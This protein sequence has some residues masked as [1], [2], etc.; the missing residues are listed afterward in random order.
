MKPTHDQP[1]TAEARDEILEEAARECM[2]QLPARA[3]EFEAGYRLACE[4]NARNIRKLK[5]KQ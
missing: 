3:G 1:Q 2:A 4:E 5:R